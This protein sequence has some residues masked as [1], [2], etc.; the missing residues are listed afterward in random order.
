MNQVWVDAKKQESAQKVE[1]LFKELR[2]NFERCGLF[3][4]AEVSALIERMKRGP[5]PMGV[6]FYEIL[7]EC[8][9]DR[10]KVMEDSELQSWIDDVFGFIHTQDDLIVGIIFEQRANYSVFLDSKPVHIDGDIIITDPGYMM[11]DNDGWS[12]CDCGRKLDVLGFTSYLTHDTIYGDWSCTTYNTD[13]GEPMG[14]FCT[15]AGTVS[16]M[17][18]DEAVRYNPHY[19]HDIVSHPHASTIVANFCGMVQIVVKEEEGNP[20]IEVVGHGINIVTGEPINFRSR[21]TGL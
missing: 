8:T 16:V 17:L 13:T 3:T 5:I 11:M 1:S 7:A 6:T 19:L 10:R 4:E 18:L 9:V 2:E 21:Q 14:T 20:C 15:I 12:R